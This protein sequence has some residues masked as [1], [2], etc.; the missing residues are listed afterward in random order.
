MQLVNEIC[1]V[2]LFM[3]EEEIDNMSWSEFVGKITG[4]ELVQYLKERK[5]YVNDD[6]NTEEEM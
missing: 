3:S 1:N 5:L 2:A 6:V 4:K